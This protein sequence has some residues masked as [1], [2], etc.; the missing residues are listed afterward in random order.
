MADQLAELKE[1]HATLSTRLVEISDSSEQVTERLGQQGARLRN[2]KG[3]V[4][5]LL[6]EHRQ[7]VHA[8]TDQ[9]TELELE[10]ASIEQRSAN[11]A[12]IQSLTQLAAADQP[13]ALALEKKMAEA[14]IQPPTDDP[15]LDDDVGD[16]VM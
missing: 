8:E 4:Q 12:L 3:Q 5:R 1:N 9:K 14:G 7:R 16:D 11:K 2:E 10:I 13:L 6:A 15:D